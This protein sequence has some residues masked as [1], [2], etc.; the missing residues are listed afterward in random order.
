[1]RRREWNR[2][3]TRNEEVLGTMLMLVGYV[4]SPAWLSTRTDAELRD[5]EWWAGM[6][7]LRASDNPVRRYPRPEIL[8]EPWAGKPAA[9]GKAFDMWGNPTPLV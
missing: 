3:W 6:T 5:I 7:H 2:Q 4:A 8:P 9:N 1:M